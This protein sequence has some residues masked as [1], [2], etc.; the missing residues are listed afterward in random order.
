MAAATDLLAAVKAG[1]AAAVEAMLAADPELAAAHENGVSATRI[2]L[3][4]RQPAVLE[5]L[6][7]A[8][9]PLDGL[10]HA[11]LG[12]ADDLRRD[13]AADP[14]LVSRRSSDG[15]TAL[16]YACF[17]GG[18]AAVAALLEA[19]ADSD[20][21]ATEPPV[22][23]LHSAAAARDAEA[24]RLL[25]E[26]GA[27]PNATQAGGF[28]ALHAAAHHDDEESAA[29]LLRHGADPALRNDEGADAVGIARAASA[30]AVLALLGA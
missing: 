19:G 17:F 25:L 5:A 1:D 8:Q 18:A 13:L 28:T 14:G 16:H 7:A 24:I 4:H 11:A 30:T 20:A 3:Y 12:W 21:V 9:P 29:L 26:A 23:P 6:L 27:D 2:A 15:F 22:R 10:D